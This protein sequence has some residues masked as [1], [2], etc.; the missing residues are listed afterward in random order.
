MYREQDPYT[1]SIPHS[2]NMC[3]RAP[4]Q[5]KSNIQSKHIFRYAFK[6]FCSVLEDWHDFVLIF[7]GQHDTPVRKWINK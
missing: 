3:H 4:L 7:S 6:Q 5:P 2:G 1:C